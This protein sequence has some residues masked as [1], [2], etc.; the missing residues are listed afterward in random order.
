MKSFNIKLLAVCIFVIVGTITHSEISSLAHKLKLDVPIRVLLQKEHLSKTHWTLESPKG[1]ILYNPESSLYTELSQKKLTI[2]YNKKKLYIDDI[3]APHSTI[4]IL[5]MDNQIL[6]NTVAYEGYFAVTYDKKSCYLI[7]HID[8]EDYLAAVLPYEAV[9]TWPDEA[10]KTLC[11]AARTYVLAKILERKR[12]KVAQPYDVQCNV[13]DQVYNGK[14]SPYC[15]KRI[16][17]A[18]RGMVVTK[19]NN[20]IMTL[21]SSACGGVIPGNRRSEFNKNYPYLKRTY[22][23][24]HCNKQKEYFRWET[25]YPFSELE[26][27]LRTKVPALKSLKD[28]RIP[29]Y[30]EAGTAEELQLLDD[31]GTWHTMKVLDFRMLFP[32]VRSYCCTLST[33]NNVLYAQGKGFGHH[34]GL[35]QWGAFYMVKKGYTHK[36]ILAFYYP[37]TTLEQFSEQGLHC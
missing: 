19:N 9:P 24:T 29:S 1:F 25:T 37:D 28:I 10:L 6:I 35:C 30:D 2:A 16:I 21:Y 11:I 23:C 7:N 34:T 3:P 15:L 33:K 4:Y 13:Y 12:D 14:K 20:L 5:P 31:T 18:T 22:A 32:T 27:K 26:K 8:L 36:E 17:D